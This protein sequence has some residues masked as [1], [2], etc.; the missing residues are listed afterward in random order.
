MAKISVIVP[1]YKT[2]KVLITTLK[3]IQ[4]QTFKD[5]ECLLVNDGSQDVLTRKICNDFVQQ[6]DRFIYFY[7]QN[8]GIEK[9]RLFGVKNA[10]TDL[11]MFC[12]HDDYYEENA[13]EIL[14]SAYL[15]SGSNIIVANC[16]SQKVRIK[17]FTK[18]RNNLGIF[19]EFVINQV[20]FRKS[21]FLNFF[22]YHRFSVSTWGKLYQRFLFDQDF[23]LFGI[24]I[25]EDIVLN[26][27][28]FQKAQ[29][30]HFIPQ[31]VYTYVYGGISSNF[32]PYE[33]LTG[34]E[35]IY[36]F[37]KKILEDNG[38]DILILLIE[39]RNIVDQRIDL[40]I[41]HNFSIDKFKEVLNKISNYDCYKDVL[42]F[43][44]KKQFSPYLE[45]L[46]NQNILD[47]YNKAKSKSTLKRKIRFHLKKI[48]SKF[49]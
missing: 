45:L 2:G 33:A 48:I 16:F 32:D 19:E 41:D 6:D 30:I 42:Q 35:K 3:S 5:F 13:L 44:P 47:V 34:Y 12:D 46:R 15:K 25:L 37:R 7:K 10:I 40:M 24:N 20:E 17:N 36:K 38:L 14:Y 11:L 22:G 18:S 29:K 31:Y 28:I 43:L 21:W 49:N 27:Q 9:T 8:E 39:Y 23:Q 4:N 1:I 26:I